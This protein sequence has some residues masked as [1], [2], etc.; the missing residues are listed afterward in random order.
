MNSEFSE[1]NPVVTPDGEL[2]LFT[3]RHDSTTG[4]RKDN[5]DRRFYEDIHIAKAVNGRF[6]AASSADHPLSDFANDVNSKR[7]EAPVHLSDDATT[8]I[9]FKDNDL[10]FS[11][12]IGDLYTVAE[13]YSKNINFKYYHRH[14]SLTNDGQTMVFTSEVLD[15]KLNRFHLDI[16]MTKIGDDGEWEK[17]VRLPT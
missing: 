2:M 12:R 16:F 14:A 17:P 10:W 4:Q 7:H 1:Y 8:I 3:T 9:L 13:K 11:E 15:K 5:Q 6:R